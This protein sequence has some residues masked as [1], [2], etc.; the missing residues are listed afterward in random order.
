M[1]CN[2]SNRK[3]QHDLRSKMLVE[4][5]KGVEIK[6]VKELQNSANGRS[7]PEGVMNGL[8]EGDVF[9]AVDS[10]QIKIIS[11]DGKFNN[12]KCLVCRAKFSQKQLN[13]HVNSKFHTDCM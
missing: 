6:S 3:I 11:I 8:K 7:E 2:S 5:L 1:G 9:L 12:L 13:D 4:Y 10:S